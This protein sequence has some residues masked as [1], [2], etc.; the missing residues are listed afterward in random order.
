MSISSVNFDQVSYLQNREAGVVITGDD[1]DPLRTLM[2]ETFNSDFAIATPFKPNQYYSSSEYS[3]NI[4]LFISPRSFSLT[5]FLQIITN[6]DPIPVVIPPRPNID[7]YDTPLINV[8]GT[9]LALL[10]SMIGLIH[11]VD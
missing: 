11:F 2:N 8:S 4:N 9:V 3:V 1:S 6:P 7:A 10:F 5:F